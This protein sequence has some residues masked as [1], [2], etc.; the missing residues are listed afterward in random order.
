MQYE[1]KNSKIQCRIQVPIFVMMVVFY[2]AGFIRNPVNPHPWKKQ[3]R[4][5][6]SVD[7]YLLTYTLSPAVNRKDNCL[8]VL[9]D[10]WHKNVPYPEVG[11]W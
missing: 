7:L 10:S 11:M 9:S 8:V 3:Y 2:S 5:V 1:K 6:L 4:G